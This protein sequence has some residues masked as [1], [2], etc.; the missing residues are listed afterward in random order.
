MSAFQ[1]FSSYDVISDVKGIDRMKQDHLASV[2][3]PTG[4][5]W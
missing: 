3:S 2:L 5:S 4:L 1:G